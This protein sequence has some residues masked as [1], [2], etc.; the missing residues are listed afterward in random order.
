MSNEAPRKPDVLP[1]CGLRTLFVD[2]LM[3]S[4]RQDG[5]HLIQF[6]ASLPDGWTE[7]T[8][9]MVSDESLKNMLSVLTSKCTSWPCDVEERDS[10]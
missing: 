9:V 5:M 4:T 6:F 7:Q 8:R 2:N 10:S 3:M 1:E